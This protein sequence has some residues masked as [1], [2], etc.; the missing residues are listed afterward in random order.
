MKERTIMIFPKFDNMEIIDEIRRK[1]DP[2]VDKVS[3]HIT[4]I[5][6]FKK[7]IGT[8]EIERW[9]DAALRDIKI[10]N[11]EL[12]GF[13]KQENQ[14]GNY[15]FLDIK[16]GANKIKEIHELLISLTKFDY[17][18]NP[19][20]TVGKLLTKDELEVAYNEVKDN[21]ASFKTIV[22]TIS[23]EIIGEDDIS[24]IEYEYNLS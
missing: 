1:N 16:Q 20:M 2:L 24:I 6:P 7:D 14:F 10:F 9:L 18:Y 11:I 17:P 4:L 23:V 12:Q 13:S 3:P 8:K 19:H 21:E 5:Y 15:L 22:E